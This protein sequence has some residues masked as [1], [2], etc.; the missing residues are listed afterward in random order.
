LINK[1]WIEW[2]KIKKLALG[3]LYFM[4]DTEIV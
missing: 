4:F 2:K 1:I 3:K